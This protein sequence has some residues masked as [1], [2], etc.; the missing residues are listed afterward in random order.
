MGYS[1]DLQHVSE[2]AYSVHGIAILISPRFDKD[3]GAPTLQCSR[4]IRFRLCSVPCWLSSGCPLLAL[5]V[6]ILVVLSRLNG[7]SNDSFNALQ[8]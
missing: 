1:R 7:K 8:S 2:S 3:H 5:R 4:N 6:G